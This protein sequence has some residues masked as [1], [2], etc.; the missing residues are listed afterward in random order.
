MSN[1]SIRF[2]DVS[3]GFRNRKPLFDGLSCELST[4]KSTGKVIALM[5]PSGVGKTTFCDLALGTH[6]PQKGLIA[7]EPSCANIAVIPQKA[8]LFNELSV[9]ENIS[10]LKFSRTLGKSY[11]DEKARDAVQVLGLTDVLRNATLAG[12]LSGGEAQRVMLAR[13]Q[14]IDCDILI[15]DEPCSFLDNR[16]KDSFLKALRETVSERGILAL[17]VTHVWNEV[18]AIA[19]EVL[20]FDKDVGEQVVLKSLAVVAASCSP[21]TIEALHCIHWPDCAVLDIS[22]RALLHNLAE[23]SIPIDAKFIGLHLG[24]NTDRSNA[25]WASKLWEARESFSGS[26][27][28]KLGA[29][30]NAPQD[31]ASVTANFYDQ[32]ERLLKFAR[33]T[34]N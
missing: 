4:T 26:F 27:S 24:K 16:V 30:T 34:S 22:N 32:D 7:I 21:P 11:D 28:G 13:I 19:D 8:V 17:M 9:Q 1:V 31:R 29:I 10:C 12:A 3:F 6:V 5:G 2:R 18:R 15:L 14:T 20:F 33:L 25:K 23:Y